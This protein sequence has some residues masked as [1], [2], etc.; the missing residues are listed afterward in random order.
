[1]NPLDDSV[2][3]SET[4]LL[5]NTC[6]LV[7]ITKDIWAD[8]CNSQSNITTDVRS[9]LDHKN[10]ELYTVRHTFPFRLLFILLAR[11]ILQLT[12]VTFTQACYLVFTFYYFTF[13]SHLPNSDQVSLVSGACCSLALW[14]LLMIT[15]MTTATT[16]TKT[17]RYGTCTERN[18]RFSILSYGKLQMQETK[19]DV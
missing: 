11:Q 2:G 12:S 7:H 14:L 18:T 10:I 9:H 19:I 16:G 17:E 4:R 13:S 5:L 1:M 6:S 8:F 15:R 3:I